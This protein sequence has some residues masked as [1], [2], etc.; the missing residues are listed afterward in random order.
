MAITSTGFQAPATERVGLKPSVYDKII[1]IGATETPIL[2]KIGVDKVTGIKHS[3]IIDRIGD[4]TRTPKLEISDFAGDGKSTKQK[5]ENAVEIFI[6]DVTV[7]KTMQKVSVYG[8]KEL[9]YEVTKK[10]KIHKKRFEQ[11]IL[12][13]GRDADVQTSVFKAPVLRTDALPG[14]AAGIFYFLAKD[15][16]AFTSGAR[17]NVLAFD[18]AGDWSG[19]AQT[20]TWDSFNAILQKVYDSGTN[21]TDAYLGAALKHQVNNLVSRFL[22]NEKKTAQTI[23]SVETDFGVINLHLSRFLGAQYGLG[24]TLIAGDFSYMKNGLLIP[25]ELEDVPT[26][27][28]AKRKRYYTEATLVVRNADAFAIGVGLA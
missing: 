15:N 24:D 10:G 28:T 5:C 25:T 16:T 14:E 8:E 6:D 26:S 19:T 11:M 13:L 17:G 23:S 2:S 7:S 20:L 21:P 9:P 4:P 3:W 1:Q 12:G 27:Q 22:G 18:T